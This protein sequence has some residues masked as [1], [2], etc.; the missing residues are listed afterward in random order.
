MLAE[1][2]E[3]EVI[4]DSENQPQMT[5]EPDVQGIEDVLSEDGRYF[6]HASNIY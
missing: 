3:D 4:Y 5:S 2:A 6:V 1:C